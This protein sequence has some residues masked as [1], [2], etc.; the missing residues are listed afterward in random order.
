MQIVSL[1][2][3]FVTIFAIYVYYLLKHDHRV[4]FLAVLSCGFILS[5]SPLLL[6]YVII[7]SLINYYLG[8]LG[9]SARWKKIAFRVGIFV[10]LLQLAIMNYA[11]FAIDPVLNLF[12]SD[13]KVSSLSDIIV[14]IGISYFTLQGIGYLIN[15]KM[16]WEKPESNFINFFLYISFYPK[17]LSGPIERSN[18]FLPQLKAGITFNEQEVSSGLRLALI[19]LFKKVVIADQL[20]PLVIKMYAALNQIDGSVLWLLVVLQ[21]LYLYFDFSGYTDIAL[22]ISRSFGIKLTPNFNRPFFAENVTTFWKRFHISLSSWFNDYI[23]RQISFKHR[24]W[25]VIASAYAVFLTFFCFGL[26]HGAGWN[27]MVLGIL[28]AI[29]INF[30]FFSKKW[31]VKLFAKLPYFFR[32]LIGRVVTCIFFGISLVF[33]FS[34]DFASTMLFFSKINFQSANHLQNWINEIPYSVYI[35]ILIYFAFEYIN[36]DFTSISLKL[37]QFMSGSSKI[38]MMFRWTVFSIMLLGIIISWNKGEQFIYSHF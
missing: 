35:F 24:R 33:F 29:A 2:F 27:F 37:L 26:W 16:N 36:N 13:F 17:F 5:F 9:G 25:G 7:Y 10:N 1:S 6:I 23:F 38:K 21:T 20:S 12:G 8:I 31:R 11:S 18:Q 19:G 14:P 28:Q 3:I 30:E 4:F 15:I 22:G 32:A 34:P